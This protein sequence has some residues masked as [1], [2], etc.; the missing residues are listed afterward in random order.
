MAFPNSADT[1]PTCED[2]EDHVA[3]STAAARRASDVLALVEQVVAIELLAATRAIRARRAQGGG[4]LGRGTAAA[5]E[6]LDALVGAATPAEDIARL[7]GAVRDGTLV[8][9]V[10]TA[11]GPFGGADV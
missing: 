1:M 11:V 6:R 2:Q 5:Y 7:A 10:I 8:E 9:G 3:M 4:A